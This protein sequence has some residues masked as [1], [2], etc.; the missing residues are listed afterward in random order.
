[1]ISTRTMLG[2][3]WTSQVLVL[4]TTRDML[5]QAMFTVPAPLKGGDF[6]SYLIIR[7]RNEFQR[8]SM[9]SSCQNGC[10]TSQLTTLEQWCIQQHGTAMRFCKKDCQEVSLCVGSVPH[11]DEAV[12]NAEKCYACCAMKDLARHDDVRAGHPTSA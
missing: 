11:Q 2:L 10:C 6:K 1:M 12:I 5:V 3:F 9:K 4:G 8:E 7:E